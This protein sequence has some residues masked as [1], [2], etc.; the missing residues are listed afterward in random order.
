[1]SEQ[2]T[3]K[4]NRQPISALPLIGSMIDGLLDEVEQQYGN[5]QSCRTQPHVL[6]DYTAAGSSRSIPSR[7][8]M[9]GFTRSSSP[10]GTG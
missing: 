5:L 10:T 1:V 9:L 8:T 4:V 2:S 7:L 3:P 6:D